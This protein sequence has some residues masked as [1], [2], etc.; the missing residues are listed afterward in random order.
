MGG[1]WTP[2]A[3]RRSIIVSHF[4]FTASEKTWMNV[5]TWG[6][7]RHDRKIQDGL[8]ERQPPWER[9]C[10]TASK[11]V[12]APV[13]LDVSS[14]D[15]NGSRDD[16]LCDCEGSTSCALPKRSLLY[17]AGLSINS[18]PWYSQA[19]PV[20]LK[21]ALLFT[22]HSS[23]PVVH[24]GCESRLR[25]TAQKHSRSDHKHWLILESRRYA[26]VNLLFGA[27]VIQL[28][29]HSLADFL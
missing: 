18:V 23:T 29:S 14:D 21:L 16:F 22:Y 6:L 9:A 24:A 11:D 1:C 4:G 28:F 17:M 15:L 10:Y 12:V 7:L 3:L 19:R 8:A 27:Q 2:A 26:K 20:L 25:T 13:Y 5:T